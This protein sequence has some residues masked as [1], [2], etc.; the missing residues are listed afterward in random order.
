MK[1]S[2][3]WRALEEVYGAGLGRSHAQ[4]LVLAEIG[5]TAEQALEQGVP[6][7]RV[8]NALCDETDATEAQ[9]W[10]YREDPRRRR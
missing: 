1:H 6:P 8:W 5:C 7:R 9:R 10:V 2:E 3:F 4:D